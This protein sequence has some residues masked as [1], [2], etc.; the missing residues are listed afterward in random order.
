MTNEGAGPEVLRLRDDADFR[1]YWWSRLLSLTGTLITLIALPVLVY[2][3]SG[4]PLLTALV[5][6]CEAVPYLLFGL[7]AG[8]LSDRWNRKRVMVSAD[9]V[10][11]VLMATVPLAHWL[12][13]LSVPHLMVIAFA[14]PAVAVFFDGANFGALPMLVGR[15]RIALANAR[16]WG[17]QTVTEIAVPSLVG[18]SLAVL[19]PATLLALDSLSYLVSAWFVLRIGRAMHDA[20]R[21]RARLTTRVLFADIREGLR[22]LVDH[23][24]VRTMTIVGSLQCVAGGGFVALMVAWCDRV[25]GIGT[26]GVRFG[27][28]YG[29]WSVGALIASLSLTRLLR[30]ATAARI[31]LYAL[32]ASA[33]LGLL[34]AQTTQWVAALLALLLWSCAYTLVVVNSISYRQEVTPEHLMSRVNTAGRMLAWGVGW[35]LGA[36]AG[37]ALS[38]AIGLRPALTVMSSVSLVAVVVAWTS[39]LRGLVN[40]PVGA[41]T[42]SSGD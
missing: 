20:T 10:N 29:G 26:E 18:V 2:R 38:H 16:V 1:R 25:L 42:A 40:R 30:V 23:A 39:P 9:V 36:V 7:F 12:D 8:A 14:V 41:S 33:A 11:A 6:A 28:V 19:H 5:S 27:L 37:G 4:S 15:D 3:L 32:P 31:T 17:A 13:V 34:A 35:T 24:G 21:E 22:F